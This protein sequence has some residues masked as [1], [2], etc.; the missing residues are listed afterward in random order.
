MPPTDCDLLQRF[1][2]EGRQDAFAELVNRRI[3]LVY[4]AALRQVSGD[5][6]RAQDIAQQV[7]I[8]LARKAH[9]LTRH[10]S[11]LG[12]L[13]TTTH[14][15]AVDAIRAEQRRQRREE[16]AHAMD[17]LAPWPAA[18][19]GH[20]LRPVLDAAMHELNE[21]ERQIVLLRFFDQ[22]SFAAIGAELGLSENAAQKSAERALDKLHAL[23]AKRGIRSTTAA[24]GVSLA[25]E[26]ALAAP[27]GLAAS[28]TGIALADAVCAGS[29]ASAAAMSFMTTT[30]ALVTLGV[31]LA[32]AG[33]AALYQ[34]GAADRTR[35]GLERARKNYA[36]RESRW[37]ELTLQTE[38]AQRR[39][40]DLENDLRQRQAAA[41]AARQASQ[42]A[43]EAERA[44][45]EKADAEKYAFNAAALPL[46][47]FDPQL[48]EL[49]LRKHRWE[50]NQ[51]YGPLFKE[52]HFTR[53]QTEKIV[54]LFADWAEGRPDRGETF[55]LSPYVNSFTKP[56]DL[57]G[58]IR[59]EFGNEVATRFL[60]L[61]AT[62]GPRGAVNTISHRL[63]YLDDPFSAQQ[64]ESLTQVLTA[65]GVGR[66]GLDKSLASDGPV[67][68]TDVLAKAEPVL[69]SKQMDGLR[70]VAAHAR[71]NALVKS[72]GGK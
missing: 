66:R 30:K 27:P 39:R 43:R 52:F 36:A 3:D 47:R 20:K 56:D 65:A 11:L 53:E 25:N 26:M 37:S 15:A 29:S 35:A 42:A 58:K 67:D 24:L 23:L 38:A 72:V 63:Y 50:V 54:Q 32:L 48:K 18:D 68:W 12:W 49:R 69:S 41:A 13:Y 6:H 31:L 40:A 7:F 8:T 2:A 45:V 57:V 34:S 46:L 51:D 60:E 10:P 5:T 33:T 16:E 19:I 44:A 14:Y 28:V 59:A 21:R 64:A 9:A 55:L 17:E 61:D 22:Q 71:L 1:V 4:A 70:A 62:R